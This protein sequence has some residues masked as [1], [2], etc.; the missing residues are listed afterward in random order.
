M[1]IEGP[2]SGIAADCERILR[3][4]PMWF[5]IESALVEY[6]LDSARLP[7]FAARRDGRIVGFILAGRGSNLLRN[8]WTVDRLDPTSGDRVLE[9]GCGPG[10]ALGLLLSRARVTAASMRIW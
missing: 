8:R 10:I 9:I 7:T 3:T 2:V 4:L 5:G 6:V 1:T